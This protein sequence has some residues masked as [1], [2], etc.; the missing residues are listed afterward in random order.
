MVQRMSG[1][2]EAREWCLRASER[3]KQARR[4]HNKNGN[5]PGRDCRDT[6]FL[7]YAV[8]GDSRSGM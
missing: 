8:P 3:T 5:S 4:R 7:Q 1:L 2:M 6:E